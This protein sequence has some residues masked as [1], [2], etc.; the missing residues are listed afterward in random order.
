MMLNMEAEEA[1][2]LVLIPTILADKLII[3]MK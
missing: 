2:R 1:I 3:P